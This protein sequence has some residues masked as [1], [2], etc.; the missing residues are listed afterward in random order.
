MSLLLFLCL[1]TSAGFAMNNGCLPYE[2]TNTLL[3]GV[4]KEIKIFKQEPAIEGRSGNLRCALATLYDINL[5]EAKITDHEFKTYRLEALKYHIEIVALFEQYYNV[6]YKG[7]DYILHLLPP[8][9]AVDVPYFG[10]VDPDIIKDKYLREKYIAALKEN[11]RN[12]A[13]NAFQGGLQALKRLLEMP[14]EKLGSIATIVFF[15]KNNYQDSEAEQEEIKRVITSSGLTKQMK[16]N[17]I[18]NTLTGSVSGEC[19][20]KNVPPAHRGRNR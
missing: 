11:E 20:D 10:S 2:D 9:G 6:N 14:D 16:D 15:I 18:N 3:S 4:R 8:E 12:G 1:Y 7:K 13:E 5:S 17:I 19:K